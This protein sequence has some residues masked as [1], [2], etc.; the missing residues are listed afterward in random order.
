[1]QVG[2]D[3]GRLPLLRRGQA[4]AQVGQQPAQLASE[5][6]KRG[7]AGPRSGLLVVGR[8]ER[9]GHVQAGI[10]AQAIDGGVNLVVG[11]LSR[12]GHQLGLPFAVGKARDLDGVLGGQ[13]SHLALEAGARSSAS[14]WPNL[15]AL[16]VKHRVHVMRSADCRLPPGTANLSAGFSGRGQS[17]APSPYASARSVQPSR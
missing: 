15:Q 13:L 3:R 14:T 16:L 10:T 4:C 6:G 8:S 1:V 9:C 11:Q 12:A 2:Q 5:V 17:P 7:T